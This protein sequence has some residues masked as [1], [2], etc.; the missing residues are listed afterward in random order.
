MTDPS[1]DHVVSLQSIQYQL[2]MSEQ[3]G[4]R[5]VIKCCVDGG[6]VRLTILVP[7]L[8][9]DTSQIK[10]EKLKLAK[11]FAECTFREPKEGY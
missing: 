1:L 3:V 7:V 6:Q 5:F 10:Q 11:Q 8:S 2:T 9:T 4:G